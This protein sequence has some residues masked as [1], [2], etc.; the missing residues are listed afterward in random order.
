[1]LHFYLNVVQCYTLINLHNLIKQNQQS[2]ML[3]T[4]TLKE[5][6]RNFQ[7]VL[8]YLK[9]QEYIF[10]FNQKKLFKKEIHFFLN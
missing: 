4:I 2:I 10:K 6:Q 9:R 5:Y 1:M 8:F 7:C 3:N